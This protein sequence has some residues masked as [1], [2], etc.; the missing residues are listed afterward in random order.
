MTIV[1][2]IVLAGVLT[3][4][5]LLA[6]CGDTGASYR[7]VIDTVHTP[8]DVVAR[9]ESD[10]AECHKLAEQ[11]GYDDGQVATKAGGAAVVGAVIGA[12]SGGL[13]GAAAGAAVGGAAGAGAGAVDIHT[14][15]QRIVVKCM[16]ARG[17]NVID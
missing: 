8:A 6:A 11:R 3:S 10:L 4:P 17:H 14:R 13:R 15:R 5:L 2:S 12:V 1:R 9:Q 7:P 16:R